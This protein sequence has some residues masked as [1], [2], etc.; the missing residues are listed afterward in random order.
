MAD[1][2]ITIRTIDKTNTKQV[3]GGF[4]ELNS[5]IALMRQGLEAA[6]KA[7]EFSRQG[8][9]LEFVS[10]KF[11]RL[12]ESI[13]TTSDALLKDLQVATKGTL[14][15]ME[16]MASATDLVGLG[17]AN[18]HD[19]A[20]RLAKVSAGLNMNMNQL[21]LT[22]TNMT[23]MRFDA[24]GVRV[25]GFKDKVKQLEEQ[26][27]STEAAF[28]EAFLQQAENQLETVGNAADST[29]GDFQRLEAATKDLT[30]AMEKSS[31]EAVVPFVRELTD[32]VKALK[33]FG[34]AQEAIEEQ[35]VGSYDAHRMALMGVNEAAVKAASGLREARFDNELF[36]ESLEASVVAQEEN[37]KYFSELL[38]LTTSIAKENENHAEKLEDISEKMADNRAEAEKLYPWELDKLAELD[39]KH[40]GLQAAYNEEAAAHEER[41][42]R[43]L[44]DLLLQK[45]SV[46]GLTQ[47]EYEMSLQAG[48]MY[49]VFDEGAANSAR[50][51][52][53]VTQA[54]ADGRLEV[55]DMQATLDAMSK[56]YNIDVAVRVAMDGPGAYLL[57]SDSSRGES[58]LKRTKGVKHASG[59]DGWLTVPPGYPNDSYP[60]FLSSGEKYAVIPANQGGAGADSSGGAG[61]SAVQLYVTIAGGFA[62]PQTAADQL[63]PALRQALRNEGVAVQQ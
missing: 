10:G 15:D 11:D 19:E 25:D 24:L 57:Q 7:Y 16:L 39:E 37:T 51:F 14:S 58:G 44:Y 1:V 59:T 9:E 26:G 36:T 42:N 23:T 21:V 27:Y 18:S 56:G 43:I 49:G 48:V 61:G 40:A 4:T 30:D 6:K 47:A 46:D 34:D 13:G 31:S 22:L 3:I 55:E 35:G 60:A 54:V 33:D 29:L 45:L 5:A 32:G 50:T 20:V 41:T 2:D 52:D 62:D 38:G 8:A 63:G 53:A 17:L 28:K 12:S